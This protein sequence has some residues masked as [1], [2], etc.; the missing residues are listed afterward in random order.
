MNTLISWLVTSGYNFE[1][2]HKEEKVAVF[3]HRHWFILAS[4]VAKFV[5]AAILP[6]FIYI[7]IPNS[8]TIS[9]DASKWIV[10]VAL[11]YYSFVWSTSCYAITMYL[12]D[13]WVVTD[14]RI[15]N[16]NQHGF[17]SRTVSE[18]QLPRIQDISVH[19]SGLIPTLLDFGNIEVQTAGSVNKFVFLQVP[20]PHK[21]KEEIM[22]LVASGHSES[23]SK[24]SI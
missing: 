2:K 24:V 12:L 15:L 6:L 18:L 9:P 22:K 8:I 11:I 13:T 4:R 5:F 19:V 10:L 14:Q 17:F 23:A 21:V 1:G 3:L 20:D 16:N 7:L